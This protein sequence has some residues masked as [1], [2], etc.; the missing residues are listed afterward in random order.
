MNLPLKSYLH[1]LK[2]YTFYLGWLVGLLNQPKIQKSIR[3]Y[4]TKFFCPIELR[5][6]LF[7]IRMLCILL[8]YQLSLDNLYQ[9]LYIQSLIQG[10]SGQYS[11]GQKNVLTGHLLCITKIYTHV[12]FYQ[13]LLRNKAI[14][15]MQ[16]IQISNNRQLCINSQLSTVYKSELCYITNALSM[17]SLLI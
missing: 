12:I 15:M 3:N 16:Q 17:Q 9:C 13:R 2:K 8:I 1:N 6:G 11:I 14:K 7:L 5:S 10:V 4:L